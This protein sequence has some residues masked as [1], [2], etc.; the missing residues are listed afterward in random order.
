[1]DMMIVSDSFIIKESISNVFKKVYKNKELKI[2]NAIGDISSSDLDLYKILLVHLSEVSIEKVNEILKLKRDDNKLLIL[3]QLKN[4]NIFKICI[5][6]NIDGYI[7]DFEDEYEFKYIMNKINGGNKFYDSQ[8][9]QSTLSNKK[10]NMYLVLTERED[11]IMVEVG[12]GLSNREIAHKL[13]VTEFT[14]K[15][16]ISSIFNKLGFKSRK[17]IIIYI[18]NR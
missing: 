18:N 14:V 4:K 6:N 2:T 17:D 10:K 3:D 12:R 11:E 16:H 1:M 5:E 7:T 13:G 8:L 9:I 15:K